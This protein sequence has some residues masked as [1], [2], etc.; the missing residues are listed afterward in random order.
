MDCDR[1]E[2]YNMRADLQDYKEQVLRMSAFI[3]AHHLCD[4]YEDWVINNYMKEG[5]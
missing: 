4:E 3:Q 5:N 2:Y 1:D